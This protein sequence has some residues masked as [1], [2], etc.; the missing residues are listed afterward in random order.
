MYKK[1]KIVES[2]LKANPFIN[3][4][5]IDIRNVTDFHSF[6]KDGVNVKP[7]EYSAE[8][9]K[10]TR[11]YLSADQRDVVSLLKPN[12]QRLYL[13]IIYEL[14]PNKDWIWINRVKY[15]KDNGKIKDARTYNRSVDELCDCGFIAPVIR[16]KD[17]FYINPS[18]IFCGSRVEKYKDKLNIVK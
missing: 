11:V 10:S 7:K 9:Q 4:F 1:P 2:R 13:W 12:A 16:Y 8:V 15:M 3:D 14:T 18:I 17:V 5:K 6:T